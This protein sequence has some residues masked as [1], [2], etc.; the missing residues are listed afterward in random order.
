[1]KHR[2]AVSIQTAATNTLLLCR[3]SRK[4]DGEC[5]EQIRDWRTTTGNIPAARELENPLT[6]RP[7]Y[8]A[9]RSGLERQRNGFT[10]V[11]QKWE[12]ILMPLFKRVR[13]N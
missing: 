10:R 1:M 9:S 2:A 6:G 3:R 7:R 12:R 4:G 8:K 13:E 5:T 11:S